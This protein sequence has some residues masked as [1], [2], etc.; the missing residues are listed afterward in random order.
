MAMYLI[1]L[2]DGQ[3]WQWDATRFRWDAVTLLAKR[4]IYSQLHARALLDRQIAHDTMHTFE[5]LTRVKPKPGAIITMQFL[6]YTLRIT[7]IIR[8]ELA[9]PTRRHKTW[10]QLDQ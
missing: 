2:I 5:A 3:H 6:D 10:Q 9:T 8:K 4:T 1:E 7:S